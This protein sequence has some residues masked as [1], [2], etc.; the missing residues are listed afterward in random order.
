MDAKI[1]LIGNQGVGKTSIA[2]KYKEGKF[3]EYTK[4][5]V[6]ASYFQKL[7]PFKNGKQLKLHIWDTTG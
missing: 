1:V 3:D 5:T 4:P 2:M 6:G 7:I